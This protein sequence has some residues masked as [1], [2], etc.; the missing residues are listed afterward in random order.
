MKKTVSFILKALLIAL[1]ACSDDF[2]QTPTSPEIE[3]S[4]GFRISSF[5]IKKILFLQDN[6]ESVRFANLKTGF[7]RL[8]SFP[9]NIVSKGETLRCEM[10]LA[11]NVNIPDGIYLLT[12]SGNDGTPVPGKARLKIEGEKVIEADEAH[13]SFSL[14][15]G[16]GTQEDPFLIESERDFMIFLD[17][18]RINELTNGRDVWFR[19]T[20]DIRLMDQSSLKPGRG[21]W[22]YSFAGHYDGG[23][24]A[25]T[26]MYYRGADDPSSDSQI[27]LFPCLLDGADI[28]HL[29]I[30]GVNIS[31]VHSDTG[32]LAGKSIGHLNIADILV[33]GNI[34]CNG[35]SIGGLIGRHEKGDLLIDGVRMAMTVEG[36]DNVGGVVGCFDSGRL[37]LKNIS[38]PEPHFSVTGNNGVAGGVGT[39]KDGDIHISEINFS[40]VVSKQDRDIRIIRTTGGEGTGV[41][42]GK[43]VNLSSPAKIESVSVGCPVGGIGETGSKIGGIIGMI[44]CQQSLT[45][46]K[47]KVTSV[48]AGRHEV[49]GL[50][51][52]LRLCGGA[53]LT[54][55]GTAS[56]NYAIPDDSAAEIM[57]HSSA[58]GAF[59]YFE[60]SGTVAQNE[61]V[62]VAL[63]VTTSEE[64]A[65][66]AIGKINNCTLNLSMFKM[67]SETMQ[68]SGKTRVGGLVGVAYNATLTGDAKFDFPFSNGKAA[69]PSPD[70][71]SP[72]FKGIVKGYSNIGGI[73]GHGENISMK[74]LSSGGTVTSTGGDNIGGIIGYVKTKGD[75][76]I[77]EDLTSKSMVTAS[78]NENVAGIF[79]CFVC[80]EYSYVT[81]C[82]NFGNIS[83]SDNAGGIAG[84]Y[85]RSWNTVGNSIRAANLRWC[86]NTGEVTANN[87]VGGIIGYAKDMVISNYAH[88]TSI[89]ISQCGNTGKVY[90]VKKTESESGV[91]GIIGYGEEQIKLEHNANSGYI[92]SSGAH[93]AV[94]GIAGSIGQDAFKNYKTSCLNIEIYQ[95]ANSGTIDATDREPRV[96]G[97]LGFMEEGPDSYLKDCVNRGKIL[98]KH[99]SDN[100]GIVGY[101]DHLTNIYNCVNLGNVENGNGTIGTHK[102]GSQF[103]HDGLYYIEDTGKGWPSATKVSE[104]KKG[105]K[106]SYSKLDFSGIW[107]IS[108]DGPFLKDCPFQFQ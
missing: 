24:H 11:E 10:R 77:F 76:N 107:D 43:I 9:V 32:T 82:I 105:D 96:G 95:C 39:I 78:S 36:N 88:K 70:S 49:G 98:N 73:V 25:L 14:R 68:V 23:G 34:A 12:F 99:N 89:Y 59:G 16:S 8:S 40:H 3:E 53:K 90:G 93:K 75:S 71:F 56:D 50:V 35:N 108:A 33:Q 85:D 37:T 102:T 52:H 74:A 7:D 44:D 42:A 54:I 6:Y 69:I 60:A 31:D 28:R 57:A 104:S 86:V 4:D 103:S 80:D 55:E 97:I 29:T 45:L 20:A 51:G 38:T 72:L 79:G 66:G 17:D 30:S 58:G 2:T 91:G 46:S 67:T 63:N 13:S 1:S 87:R 41:A 65:G 81:D 48:V 62:R 22:G 64:Q 106:N 84:L 18:L 5:N 47:C 61:S 15:K 21:Y 19:Q 92:R 101:V 26:D 94:G 83:A 27:G 100:G